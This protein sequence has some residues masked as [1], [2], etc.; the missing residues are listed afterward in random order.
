MA[1]AEIITRYL[2]SYNRKSAF[3]CSSRILLIIFKI[4]YAKFVEAFLLLKKRP[5]L[6]RRAFLFSSEQR[7]ITLQ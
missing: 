6:S 5:R 7:K 3:Y 2:L 1:I 4:L